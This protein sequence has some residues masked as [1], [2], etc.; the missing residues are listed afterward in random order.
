MC[1]YIWG[2]VCELAEFK[3]RYTLKGDGQNVRAGRIMANIDLIGRGKL[4]KTFE[5]GI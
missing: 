4:L 1:G 2:T 5:H 3:S